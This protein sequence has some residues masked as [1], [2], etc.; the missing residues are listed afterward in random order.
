M[1]IG[2]RNSTP[3]DAALLAVLVLIGLLMIGGRITVPC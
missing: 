3:Y 2:N 1:I